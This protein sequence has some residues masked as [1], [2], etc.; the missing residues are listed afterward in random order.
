MVPPPHRPHERPCPPTHTAAGTTKCTFVTVRLLVSASA[1]LPQRHGRR[2]QAG[3]RTTAPSTGGSRGSYRGG[4]W[5]SPLPLLERAE[6]NEACAPW[7]LQRA[8]SSAATP[9]P[10]NANEAEESPLLVGTL[11]SR[12][13]IGVLPIPSPALGGVV[14]N[15]TLSSLPGPLTILHP[16]NPLHT[17]PCNQAKCK[18]LHMGWGNSQ[19][20]HR[21]GDGWMDGWMDGEQP[22]EEGLGDSGG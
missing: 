12:S 21:L 13:C 8:G 4:R 16:S 18:I 5:G 10:A 19:D 20:Q 7:V 17:L 22:C 14:S 9:C 2:K 6:P 15:Q 1:H 3:S 11:P